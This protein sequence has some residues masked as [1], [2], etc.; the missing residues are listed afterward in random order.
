MTIG[1]TLRF[2]TRA[3]KSRTLIDHM[4]LFVK[5]CTSTIHNILSRRLLRVEENF[6]QHRKIEAIRL[7][8]MWM[9]EPDEWCNAGE[10]Y[11]EDDH[12]LGVQSV[13]KRRNKYSWIN[14]C[15][16]LNIFWFH[17]AFNWPRKKLI[18]ITFDWIEFCYWISSQRLW[19]RARH[20][21]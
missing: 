16:G 14:C 19:H 11:D 17:M 21:A 20:H 10:S 5:A 3:L 2:F 18:G 7:R 4:I 1:C 15:S 6:A 9:R 8:E 12:L 13:E